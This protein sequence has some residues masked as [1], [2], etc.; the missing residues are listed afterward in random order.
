M[1]AMVKSPE[2]ELAAVFSLEPEKSGRHSD[3]VDLRHPAEEAGADFVPV[4]NIN[5]DDSLDRLQSYQPDYIFVVGWSQICGPELMAAAPDRVIGYHPAPLPRMRG[6]AAIPW[7]ILKREPITAGT[8]FWI[9]SGV[10]TGPILDQ[11]FFHVDPNE[12]ASSLYARHMR[13][14]TLMLNRTLPAVAAGAARRELQD[15]RFATWATR[16][17]PADGLI[18]WRAP[19]DEIATLVRAVGQPYS[20]AFADLPGGRVTIWACEASSLGRRYAALPGQ[21]IARDAKSFTI[22]CGADTAVTV[23]SWSS[24]DNKAP[25]MHSLLRLPS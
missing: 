3:F 14:L 22:V 11:H 19:A 17:T 12:T 20:G 23:T 1:Q 13:A 25:A 10:D 9:D 5:R 7:T 24:P 4:V 16:R 15:E 6:R 8:L 18:D 21:V 2:C